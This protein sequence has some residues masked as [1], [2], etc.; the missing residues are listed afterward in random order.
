MPV[1]ELQEIKQPKSLPPASAPVVKIPDGKEEESDAELVG[2]VR[3]T[4]LVL[5]FITYFAEL[6]A[7]K[8]GKGT[9]EAP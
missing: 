2:E 4:H 8:P 5:R 9:S 7:C 1:Q 3:C 6:R